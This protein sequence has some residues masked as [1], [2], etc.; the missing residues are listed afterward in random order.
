VALTAI[1]PLMLNSFAT[2]GKVELQTALVAYL[3]L[4]VLNAALTAIGLFISSL[5][6][7]QVVAA[8][9]SFG[10]ALALWFM[11][12]AARVVDNADAKAALG[13]ASP[14]NHLDKFFTG[15][16]AVADL[17]YFLSLTV[18]GLVLSRA[19]IERSRW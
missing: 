11:S 13:Y 15:R 18:L 7:S 1:Y 14:L 4:L 5:T 12:F 17:T 6:E 10:V 19:S 8:A 2:D 9:L 16:I 3:G